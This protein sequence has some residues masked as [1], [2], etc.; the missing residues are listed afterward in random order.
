MTESGVSSQ[1]SS[2][3]LDRRSKQRAR[4]FCLTLKS[5]D[6]NQYAKHLQFVQHP[7]QFYGHDHQLVIGVLVSKVRVLMPVKDLMRVKSV[8]T[9]TSR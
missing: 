2:S 3:S 9:K 5:V 6:H 4:Y 1:E 8:V 7:Q